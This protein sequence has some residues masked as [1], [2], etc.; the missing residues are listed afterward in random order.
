MTQ[1]FYKGHIWSRF[2]SFCLTLIF[3]SITL[4][5]FG[6]RSEH[7][8]VESVSGIQRACVSEQCL[9]WATYWF[10]LDFFGI[11]R[12]EELRVPLQ[13]QALLCYSQVAHAVLW[14]TKSHIGYAVTSMSEAHE[15][16]I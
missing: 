11:K 9:R 8:L 2:H 10:G 4:T 5:K 1:C 12:L 3:S 7:R 6:S 15:R 13:F 14:G 16:N